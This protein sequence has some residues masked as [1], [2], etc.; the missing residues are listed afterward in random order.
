MSHP[1]ISVHGLGKQFQ[2]TGRAGGYR[3]LR[4]SMVDAVR[5][6]LRAVRSVGQTERASREGEIFWALRDISFDV[7]PGEVMGVVGHN[8]AGKSTLLKV[9]SRITEPSVGYADVRGRIGSLL[10]VG[11]GFHPELS[12][13]ENVYL[14]GAILG[15]RRAEIDRK[16]DEIVD[17]AEVERFIDTPVKH[18]S[19]GMYLRLAF[20]V[21]AHLEP[22]VL[23]V[24]EVLA[25]GDAAFQKKCLGKMGEVA[26]QGRTILFVSHNMNAVQRLCSRCI[27]LERGQMKACG[28]TPEIV[29]QYLTS[30]MGET[31]PGFWID[32]T[33]ASR[34]GTGEARVA[35]VWYS[36]GEAAAGF[37]PYPEGPLEFRLRVHSNADREV[38]SMAVVILDQSHT[39][40]VNA[41]TLSLGRPVSLKAGENVV[42]IK[43]DK[44]YLNPGVYMVALWIANP[45]GG[46][47]ELA[48][49]AFQ[50]E[51]AEYSPGEVRTRPQGD[52]TVPCNF[53]WDHLGD[54]VDAASDEAVLAPAGSAASSR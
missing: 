42:Q 15:M 21:A 6:P 17:F 25:V 13:R 4:E 51:V 20:A 2:L 1:A 18:Y 14:N 38:G 5:K 30:G 39:K 3:T 41:D 11:T 52:G 27:L 40:L 50:L 48:E 9:L 22:E 16:F 33:G 7:A 32:V 46:I 26:S 43:I 31:A 37:R 12:G 8:G 49:S 28:P 47:F 35:G 24:D 34:R 36:S 54:D 23:V 10:E 44:L 45:T 53:E 29:R 19:S